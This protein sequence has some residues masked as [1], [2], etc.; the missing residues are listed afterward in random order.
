VTNEF[1]NDPMRNFLR[2]IEV[3]PLYAVLFYTMGLP[4]FSKIFHHEM[5]L[6]KYVGM[7]ENTLIGSFPGVSPAIYLLGLMEIGVPIL[8]LISAARL[9]FLSAKPKLWLEAALILTL[10]TFAALGFGLRLIQNNDGAASLYFYFG[11]TLVALI[12]VRMLGTQTK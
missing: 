5:V 3:L 6:P 4:G 11:A 10:A 1:Y 8:I 12:W 7:F 9:E 2:E